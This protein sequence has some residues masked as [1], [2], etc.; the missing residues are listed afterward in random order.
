M[1]Q[2][3]RYYLAEVE[4]LEFVGKAELLERIRGAGEQ[5][6][7]LWLAETETKLADLRQGLLKAMGEG[8]SKVLYSRAWQQ[9]QLEFR[10]L[11]RLKAALLGQNP[12]Q[13]QE[14][15]PLIATAVA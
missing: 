9:A 2:W 10:T 5:E 6:R 14:R 8:S 4:R 15:S 1:Q 12:D 11:F 13:A 7:E 3:Q